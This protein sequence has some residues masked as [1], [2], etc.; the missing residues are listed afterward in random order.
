[1]RI[2]EFFFKIE[3]QFNQKGDGDGGS[4]GVVIMGLLNHLYHFMCHHYR[5]RKIYTV[6]FS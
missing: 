3:E 4:T 6:Q 2:F 1:M 5:D